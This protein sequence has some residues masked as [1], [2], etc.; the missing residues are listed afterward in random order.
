MS[1]KP[2]V[3]PDVLIDRFM[4]NIQFTAGVEGAADLLRAPFLAQKVSDQPEITLG[5]MPVPPG[6]TAPG[7][8]TPLGLAGAVGPVGDMTAIAL[9]F[10][11]DGAP[12]S[13]QA[14]GNPGHAELLQ[15]EFANA[16]PVL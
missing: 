2:F 4:G 13:A 7:H 1:A 16:Y 9:K 5:E 6:S 14:F 15:S 10:P 12:V 8:S 3:A 11:V